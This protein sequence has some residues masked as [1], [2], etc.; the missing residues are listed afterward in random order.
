MNLIK[1]GWLGVLF[2]LSLTVFAEELK[3]TGVYNGINIHIQNPHDGNNNYCISAI[4]LNNNQVKVPSSTIITLDLANM[5]L[6]IGEKVE[7]K[8]VHQAKCKPKIINP[9]ALL[10][11]GD[12]HFGKLKID[13]E[14]ISWEG[15]GESENGQYF[16]ESF[17]NSTWQAEK[18]IPAQGNGVSSYS[19]RI[20]HTTG[21]NKYRIKYVDNPEKHYHS[22]ELEF[23]SDKEKIYFYPKNVSTTIYFSK[24]VKYEILDANRKSVLK[25]SGI[26]IDCSH[27]PSGSYYIIY[28]NRTEQFY[29]KTY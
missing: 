22:D 26:E 27:L 8:I 11:R 17:K 16:I 14:N 20:N 24:L 25:G 15:K 29:K 13:D 12:F 2:L 7:I 4:Y 9:N 5:N 18:I 23:I 21:L 6:K 1:V 3:L 19:V 10:V 28:D